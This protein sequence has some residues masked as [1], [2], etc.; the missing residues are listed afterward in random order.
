MAVYAPVLL[1]N[2]GIKLS[3]RNLLFMY[4][5]E[6]GTAFGYSKWSFGHIMHMRGYTK[7]VITQL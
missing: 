4:T 6:G 5:N 2:G 1:A 3:G 7:Y